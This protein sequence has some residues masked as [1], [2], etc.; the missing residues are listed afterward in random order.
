LVLEE[1]NRVNMTPLAGT[2][3]DSNKDNNS[4]EED[5]DHGLG[6][7]MQ[8]YF[9]KFNNFNLDKNDNDDDENIDEDLRDD[10]DDDDELDRDE[11]GSD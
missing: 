8:E 3:E 11:A 4:D 7:N 5:V 10:D 2:Q 6:F 9:N 1:Q